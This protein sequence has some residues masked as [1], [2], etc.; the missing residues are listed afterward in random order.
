MLRERQIKRSHDTYAPPTHPHTHK[1]GALFSNTTSLQHSKLQIP[2]VNTIM[3]I[4]FLATV[5]FLGF[6]LLFICFDMAALLEKQTI[7]LQT[8]EPIVSFLWAPVFPSLQCM[9]SLFWFMIP[10]MFLYCYWDLKVMPRWIKY[11]S[12]INF[13][14]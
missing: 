3:W 4:V 9:N 13:K 6:L 7:W 14:S 12:I 1:V 11:Q 10:W 2:E 5:C 8:I